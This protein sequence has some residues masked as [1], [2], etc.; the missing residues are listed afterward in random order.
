MKRSGP[1]TDPGGTP[2]E[3]PEHPDLWSLIFTNCLQSVRYDVNQHL[4]PSCCFFLNQMNRLVL[5]SCCK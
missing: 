3:T 1:K 5:M 2:S 4:A